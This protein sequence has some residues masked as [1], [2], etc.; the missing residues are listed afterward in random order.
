MKSV[1]LIIKL[2]ITLILFLNKY[3]IL[4][5]DIFMKANGK[6][7]KQGR[8]VKNGRRHNT[9]PTQIEIKFRWWLNTF[10]SIFSGCI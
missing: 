9:P 5:P 8:C 1:T 2:H 6:L 3:L 4:L 10:M 7:R